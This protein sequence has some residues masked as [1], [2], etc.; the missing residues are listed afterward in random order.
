VSQDRNN[1]FDQAAATWDDN[2]TRIAMMKIVGTAI[3][4]EARPDRRTWV[5]DYGCGTGLIGLFLLPHVGSVTGADSSSGMLEVLDRKVHEQGLAGMQTLQL[6]LEHDPVELTDYHRRGLTVGVRLRAV[7]PQPHL[8]VALDTA[9]VVVLLLVGMPRLDDPRVGSR[10]VALA[11]PPEQLVVI[12]QDLHEVPAVVGD[13]AQALDAHAVD[14]RRAPG[15][16][17]PR[18]A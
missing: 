3:L 11:E 16:V 7:V 4:R 10:E 1:H 6:D 5:L 14:H 9:E 18:V 12:A 2:P 15:G 8:H 17:G 13:E